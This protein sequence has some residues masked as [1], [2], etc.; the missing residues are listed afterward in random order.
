MNN[1]MIA[2]KKFWGLYLRYRALPM[3]EAKCVAIRW[4]ERAIDQ[5]EWW[6]RE[7]FLHEMLAFR[8]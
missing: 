3:S 5:Y 8:G 2:D 1:E 6:S 7:L 4:M